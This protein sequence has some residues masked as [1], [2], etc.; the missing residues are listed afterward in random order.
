MNHRIFERKLRFRFY[1]TTSAWVSFQHP[2]YTFVGVGCAHLGKFSL[3]ILLLVRW[4]A[5]CQDL[6]M[7]LARLIV[8]AFELY[9]TVWQYSLNWG[10]LYHCSPISVALTLR[11]LK[12]DHTCIVDVFVFKPWPQISRD[13]PLNLSILISGGKETNKDSL[14][15]GEWSG[16]S[17]N[18][19]SAAETRLNCS[20][21][22]RFPSH[23]QS[24]L[25]EDI[26]EGENPV[27]ACGEVTMRV[28]RVGLLGIAVQNGW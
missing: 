25:E 16:K 20:L 1:W 2:L 8:S 17:S 28:R 13:Y 18:L 11:D 4:S 19:K 23:E 21:E 22:M 15:N 14:S 10:W 6:D 7:T 12:C 3:V 26:I 27:W 5:L 9:A 24:S